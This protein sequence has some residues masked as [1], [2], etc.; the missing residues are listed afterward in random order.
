MRTKGDK[1]RAAV[2]LCIIVAMRESEIIAP[3][4]EGRFL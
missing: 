4:R 2:R 3:L 1:D